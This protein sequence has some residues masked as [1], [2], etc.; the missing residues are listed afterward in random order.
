MFRERSMSDPRLDFGLRMPSGLD[1]C[2]DRLGE[3]VGN[4]RGDVALLLSDST[5][6]V[7]F[8]RTRRRASASWLANSSV[9][10]SVA[11]LAR[12]NVLE[13]EVRFD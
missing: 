10:S 1:D 8:S 5:Y 12:S 11:V 2:A 6:E 9:S 3:S 13:S 7:S 4:S